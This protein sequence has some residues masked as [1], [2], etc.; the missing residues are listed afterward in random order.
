MKVALYYPWLYL[1]SGAERTIL[2][3]TGR[4]RHQWT[5]FTNRFEPD[6]TFPGLA[7]R[8]VVELGKVPVKRTFLSALKGALRILTQPIPLREFDAL[9]IVCEGFGDLVLFRNRRTPALCVCLTPLRLAFDPVYRERC[10]EKRK[11]WERL[12]IRAGTSLFRVVD[13]WA[14]KRYRQVI[15]ISTEAKNRAVAGR[16]APK[17]A[18]EVVHPGLGFEPTEPSL[19]FEQFFLLPGRIM[20]TKNIELGIEAFLRFRTE[21]REGR[22]FRLV[23]AGIVDRKSEPYLAKLRSLAERAE[24]SV[25]F[26]LH[27][28]DAELAGL[29]GSCYATLF[30]AFN[31]DWGIVPLESMAFGKPTIAVNRGGPKES[32]VNEVTGFLVEPAANDFAAR[33]AQLAGDPALCARMGESGHEH[34]KKYSWGTFTDHIDGVIDA[35]IPYPAQ[36]VSKVAV[37][38]AGLSG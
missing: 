35:L 29:Y 30:T 26:R 20:W 23:I 10:L 15:A 12:S 16:L 34:A 11:G 32:V 6:N 37:K 14:W 5:I 13:R 38:R 36:L 2:E 7:R 28:S 22:Q 9:V 4:S 18:I 3:L 19:R 17:D 25:E 21:Y 8:N 27:P 1:T 31:E 33:M 24:G